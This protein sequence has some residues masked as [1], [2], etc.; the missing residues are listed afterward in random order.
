MTACYGVCQFT[1]VLVHPVNQDASI[2]H[3]N[4]RIAQEHWPT[5]H[6]FLFRQVPT[7]GPALVDR[8]PPLQIMRTPFTHW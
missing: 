8:P 5:L 3:V 6:L 7:S 1:I 4:I 2:S